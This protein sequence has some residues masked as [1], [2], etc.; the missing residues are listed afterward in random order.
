MEKEWWCLH[1]FWRGVAHDVIIQTML[2]GFILHASFITIMK[3]LWHWLCD[4]AKHVSIKLVQHVCHEQH[5][6]N[7]Q[8]VT[9][10]TTTAVG[11]FSNHLICSSKI[12]TAQVKKQQ[13]KTVKLYT[14]ENSNSMWCAT[15]GIFAKTSFMAYQNK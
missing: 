15:K 13:T 11:G 8:A 9:C 1:C 14:K 12:E 10:W 2:R 6:Q 5:N 4:N 3:F 7:I